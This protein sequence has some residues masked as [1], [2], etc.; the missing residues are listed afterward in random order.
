MP[1]PVI[2]KLLDGDSVE[3]RTSKANS[4]FM[5]LFSILSDFTGLDSQVNKTN[6]TTTRSLISLFNL[7][8]TINAR[9][10]GMED[11]ET[12]AQFVEGSIPMEPADK[13]VSYKRHATRDA[14]VATYSSGK[15]EVFGSM[16]DSST[17]SRPTIQM[18]SILEF[19]SDA[20]HSRSVV[21]SCNGDNNAH[22]G[23]INGTRVSASG[24]VYAVWDSSFTG[25][26]R[27]NYHYILW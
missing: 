27:I 17:T 4:N 1:K 12:I 23:I 13:I 9:F 6:K 18:P 16:T 15:V 20:V 26:C 11:D 24:N 19:K 5:N 8:E 7:I 3:E 2:K 14:M 10:R 21:Y 22:P 25:T